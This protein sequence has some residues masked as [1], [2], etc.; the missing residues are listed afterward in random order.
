MLIQNQVCIVRLNH[1][2]IQP[3]LL[4]FSVAALNLRIFCSCR[5]PKPR[6]WNIKSPVSNQDAYIKSLI[7]FTVEP[8]VRSPKMRRINGRPR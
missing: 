1:V 2:G 4:A 3:I 5:P 6:T 7:P 8:L